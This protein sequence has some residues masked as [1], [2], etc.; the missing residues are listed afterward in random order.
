MRRIAALLAIGLTLAACAPDPGPEEAGAA[1]TSVPTTSPPTTTTVAPAV[2]E[3]L[4][5]ARS[6][7]ESA[8]V[9]GYAY[10]YQLFCEC[11]DATAG[12]NTVAVTDG[13]IVAV[14]RV[15]TG[16]FGGPDPQLPGW[17]VEQLFA[18]IAASIEAGQQV[19]VD[20]D[21]ELGHPTRIRLDLESIPVD[22]GFSMDITAF[23]D[24]SGERRALAE[25]RQRWEEA[26]LESFTY[27]LERR[28]FC[29]PLTMEIEVVDGEIVRTA[30]IEGEE[31]DS[32]VLS[33][34]ELFEVVADA[35]D[36]HP[37]RLS[38]EYDPVLG[39]PREIWVDLEENIADEEYGYGVELTVTG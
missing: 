14:R 23:S 9:V 15:E 18:D 33:I 10:T 26:A 19:E 27:T 17:T 39:Y 32:L 8:A 7:W 30:V 3:R 1:T 24:Q 6:R 31:G 13:E 38:V 22:G 20:Y 21:P 35:L 16:Q 36:E 25:A 5:E 11:D 12:P 2:G 28:C 29:I 4:A 37:A 34:D